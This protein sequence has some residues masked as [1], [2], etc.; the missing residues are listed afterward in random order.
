MKNKI[1]QLAFSAMLATV[2]ASPVLA[3]TT[4]WRLDSDHSTAGCF[5]VLQPTQTQRLT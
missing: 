3:Q 1:P 5:S 2:L 4:N